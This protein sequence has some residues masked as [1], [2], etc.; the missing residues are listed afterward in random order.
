M[1]YIASKGDYY[2]YLLIST[3]ALKR[4]ARSWHA[5]ALAERS[6]AS[7]VDGTKIAFNQTPFGRKDII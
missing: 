7:N 6:S 3:M 1:E 4:T 2:K 5:S